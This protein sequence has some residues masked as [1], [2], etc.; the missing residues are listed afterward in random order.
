MTELRGAP[1]VPRPFD[2]QAL[3]QVV[4]AQAGAGA[5]AP[6]ERP[7]RRSDRARRRVDVDVAIQMVADPVLE[8]G[9]EDVGGRQ[10]P[11]RGFEADGWTLLDEQIASGGIGELWADA[12]DEGHAEVDV[13]EGRARR[14]DAPA[15]DDHARHLELDARVAPAK[16]TRQPPG[17][18]C[19][20]AIER[21]G[22]GEQ[23]RARARRGQLEIPV[24]V[25]DDAAET[26]NRGG[27]ERLGERVRRRDP[28][29]RDDDHVQAGQIGGTGDHP[30][31]G[32]LQAASG[33]DGGA[34]GD[35]LGLD[36]LDRT[37]DAGAQALGG[38]E[39][40]EERRQ[41]RVEA[42]GNSEDADAHVANGIQAVVFR[43]AGGPSVVNVKV[44]LL[45]G[46][47]F[48][49]PAGIWRRGD[50]MERRAHFPI[51]VYLIETGRER[52]LVDTGLA[53]LAVENPVA[54]YASER[55]AMFRLGQETRLAEQ[56]DLDS[57]TQ[58][59]MTHL[60][61]DHAGGLALLPASV[62]VVVQ[63][64]E[65][66]AGL[67]DAAIAK[68][69]YLPAD[70]AAIADRVVLVDGD[71]DLLGD[72]S[73]R[74]LSTPGHTPGHQSVIVGDMLVIGGDVTHYASGLDDLRFPIL[75]DDHE[76][77]RDSAERLRAL[78]DA[79]M[80]VMPGHDPEVLEL[81]LAFSTLPAVQ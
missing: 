61:F 53:P 70:Y 71:R 47:W 16:L 40:V 27:R 64:R 7:A 15:A 34:A 31:G 39:H 14:R 33:Q 43:I 10:V 42:T 22:V 11:G 30:I 65:W 46:G 12:G 50:D 73:V 35:D 69:F 21:A 29:A 28:E 20:P 4:R 25:A 76:A 3:D 55:M 13:G 56:V 45:N 67:D 17:R 60:H 75:G 18:R 81:G 54:H 36:R 66:E 52:I 8:L 9:D 5:A 48:E 58:V 59:V 26:S 6:L 57:I 72:G 80:T 49:A 24:A 23:E 77:Q 19:G 63:R 51:P 62:P 41:A 78:R 79:G 38:R 2:P 32:D 68:N 74:L 1:Q 44:E 37:V